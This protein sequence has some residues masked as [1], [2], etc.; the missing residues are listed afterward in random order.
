V[1]LTEALKINNTS[2]KF[3]EVLNVA[4]VCGFEP[5]HLKTFLAAHTQLAFP[6][7][8]IKI[9][10]G[11]YGDFT[12]N[13]ERL[14]GEDCDFFVLALEWSD[15][16]LRL[17]IRSTSKWDNELVEDIVETARTRFDVIFQL[18]EN[19]KIFNNVII[20]LPTLPI[21]SITHLPSQQSGELELELNN[22][23]FSFASKICDKLQIKIM[24]W[25]CLNLRS[26]LS[27][28]FDARSE[29]TTGFPY[30]L[31]HAS[32]M[33]EI[34]SLLVQS[35]L[36]KKG[37]V[38][39][40]D[41]TLWAGV[42]GEDGVNGISWDLTNHSHGHVLYQQLLHSLSRAGVLIAVASKNDLSLVREAFKR[43]DLILSPDN[44]FPVE[45]SW[46]AKSESIGRILNAW[47]VGAESVVFIDDSPIEIAEVNAAFPT[48]QS[49]LFPIGDD[50][51]IFKLVEQLRDL[52]GKEKILKE[53]LIRSKSLQQKEN[54]ISQQSR[55]TNSKGSFLSQAKAKISLNFNN[56]KV[57]D[58]RAFELV[59]KTNQF[60]LNGKRYTSAAWEK[61]IRKPGCFLLTANYSDKY[62]ALGKISVVKGCRDGNR[63]RINTWV[64]SCRAFSRHIEY[65]LLHFLFD[66]FGTKKIS[67]D[68]MSTERNKPFQ[69]FFVTLL[70]EK[71]KSNFTL[72]KQVFKKKCPE[73][74]H[75]LVNL[76]N[77]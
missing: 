76:D 74:F 20:S 27:D 17:G 11:L 75:Q 28:R 77:V 37:L 53:D 45:A 49:L 6:D 65:G 43:K 31:T 8:R 42:L 73:L 60:N 10:T 7:H 1:K 62:S 19:Y 46:G 33:A 68:F 52:F 26:P 34:L 51:A 71:S 64:L 14:T 5:L 23:V 39:D 35:P 66:K 30:S 69:D 41:N 67:F 40:L 22:A 32:M 3:T 13:L 18:L 59:N 9:S 55:H 58:M 56:K 38:T 4:L 16:D 12:G 21:L 54:F 2:H 50:Q 47:N 70:G 63:V 61:D 48:L 36:P 44:L 57:P 15:L 24:S 25:Q 29:L 72:D